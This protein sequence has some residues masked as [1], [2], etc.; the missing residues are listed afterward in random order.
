MPSLEA[1]ALSKQFGAFTALDRVSFRFD[2]GGAVGYLGPNGAG[3]TTTLKLFT[4][5]L[6][7]S[8]GRALV[9]G[10]DVADDPKAALW[11]VGAMVESP[12]PYPALTGRESLR[13]IG[14][15]RG[16]SDETI[17]DRTDRWSKELELPPLDRRTATLS[18]GQK[19]RIVLAGA[20]LVE[21]SV[22]LL[23]EP[24]SG[25]D[26]AERVI[27][28][29]ILL[30]LR[31]TDRL[32]L[33]ISHLLQEVTEI[34]D[35]VI[36][37][38]QG[39]ILIQDTVQAVAQR[40]QVTKVDVEFQTPVAAAALRAVPGV[41]SVEELGPSR[42]RLGFDGSPERRASLLAGC[43]KL[44]PVV[45]FA[46]SSLTLEDAYLKLIQPPGA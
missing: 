44:A 35:R 41:D 18:K 36:F 21:P 39:R 7:A 40:F 25:L 12:E 8:A 17:R 14:R 23:D 43:Q 29:N 24:T 32:I 13:M 26:P 6:R 4:H 3:K 20:L 37:L 33:M 42:F 16:L 28:R 34:C 1:E 31:Q 2:G 46:S 27:V 19:Q 38:N 15:F 10:I 5:L 30:R 45:S 9:N 22:L 11:N